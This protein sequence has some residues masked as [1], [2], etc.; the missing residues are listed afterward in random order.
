MAETWFTVS[1]TSGDVLRDEGEA[2][3]RSLTQAGQAGVATTSVR[4]NG[5][6]HD[7]MMLNPR[8]PRWGRPFTRCAPRCTASEP[9]ARAHAEGRD[10]RDAVPPFVRSVGVQ[11]EFSGTQWE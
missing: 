3:A 8:R 11:W 4:I 5:I 9:A 10:G 1:A 2:Y 6:L 7:V